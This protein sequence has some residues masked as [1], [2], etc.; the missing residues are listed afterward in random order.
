MQNGLSSPRFNKDL[1]TVSEIKE[2]ARESVEKAAKGA[3]A[4]SMI[5]SARN[6]ALIAQECE[7]GGDFRG[8]LG[9]YI[10]AG[11][12]AKM[13]LDSAEFRAEAEPGK[14][15]VLFHEFTDFTKVGIL[16]LNCDAVLKYV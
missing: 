9:A 11:A 1:T 10:K 6:Q 8:A 3:S 14:K 5:K 16:L 15:G 13:V 7:L 2:R 4:M 12:L